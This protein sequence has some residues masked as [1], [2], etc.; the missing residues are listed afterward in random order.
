MKM[1]PVRGT[2][3]G[4]PGL[5]PLLIRAPVAAQMLG[6]SR[7]TLYDRVA[8]GRCPAPIQWHGTTVWRVADLE[9]FVKNM[10]TTTETDTKH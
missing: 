2:D 9:S 7:S 1:Q 10:G 3:T 8:K 4:M 6:V 5:R